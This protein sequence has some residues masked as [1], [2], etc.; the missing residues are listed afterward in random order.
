MLMAAEESLYGIAGNNTMIGK[1]NGET[2][3]YGGSG[4]DTM[5]GE[6]GGATDWMHAGTGADTYT[7]QSASSSTTIYGF[8]ASKGD[9]INLEDI[10]GS[11]NVLSNVGNYV[12]ET[13]SAAIR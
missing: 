11:T 10:L 9:V 3:Y 13:T 4:N 5:I 12:Q 8:S 7:I 2:Y 1:A 6:T